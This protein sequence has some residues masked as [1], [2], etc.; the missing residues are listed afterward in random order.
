MRLAGAAI[1]ETQIDDGSVL[2][3]RD[4]RVQQRP[5][6]SK[7][8]LPTVRQNRRLRVSLKFLPSIDCRNGDE[9]ATKILV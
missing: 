5:P 1:I 6:L 8:I 9:R 4:V 7:N 3:I 2:E